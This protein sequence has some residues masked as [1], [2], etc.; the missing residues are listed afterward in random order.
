[1]LHHGINHSWS[2]WHPQTSLC[3][4]S[5]VAPGTGNPDTAECKVSARCKVLDVTGQDRDLVPRT[6]EDD[7]NYNVLIPTACVR[8]C[9]Q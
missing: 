9:V 4:F 2:I 7:H 3:G 5:A 1:M 6:E 8:H